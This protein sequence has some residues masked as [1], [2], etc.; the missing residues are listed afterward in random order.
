MSAC[1]AMTAASALKMT[2]TGRSAPGSIKKNGFRLSSDASA[3]SP[4]TAEQ[5]RPLPQ[6]VEDQADL[7]ERPTDVNALAADMAHV[8]IQRLR[9]VAARN[10]LPRIIKPSLL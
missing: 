4:P 3:A 7:D 1:E 8:G 6:I 2:A 10:T 9:A 5:P